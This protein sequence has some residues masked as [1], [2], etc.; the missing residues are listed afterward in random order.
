VTSKE[1]DRDVDILHTVDKTFNASF[2]R[3]IEPGS[4]QVYDSMIVHEHANSQ[5][6]SQ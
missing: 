4:I 2:K 5:H 1:Y 6:I 3:S